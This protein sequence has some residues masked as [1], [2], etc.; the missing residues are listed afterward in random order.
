MCIR[1]SKN[2]SYKELEN[3]PLA[4]GLFKA[5]VAVRGVESVAFAG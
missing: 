4:G 5:R 1:D 3:Q 2:L